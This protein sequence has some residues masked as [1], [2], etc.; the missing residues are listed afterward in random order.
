MREVQKNIFRTW[1]F[2][3]P[4]IPLLFCFVTP[5]YAADVTLQWDA[6]TEPDLGAYK[7]YYKTGSSGEP[8]NGIGATEGASPID[9]GNV[10]KFTLHGLTDGITYFFAITAYDTEGLESDYSNVVSTDVVSTD[11]PA[12]TISTSGASGGGDGGCFIATAVYSSPMSS[13]AKILRQ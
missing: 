6:N 13:K 1:R 3:L 8:Y 2:I 4:S 11:D 9:V 7:V 10:A 5:C 12:P